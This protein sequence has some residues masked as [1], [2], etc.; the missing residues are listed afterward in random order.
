MMKCFGIIK[1]KTI[2]GNATHRSE[3][4]AFV[5]LLRFTK[6][7]GMKN[8]K[9]KSNKYV[10]KRHRIY[11][12]LVR[13]VAWLIAAI[14]HFK[15]KPKK[16]K[17]GERYLILANHQGMLDPVF[18][19]LSFKAPVYIMATDSIF[20]T[21]WYS[22]LMSHCFA[23]IKKRKG[24]ADISSIRTAV[25]IAKEGGNVAL[26]PEGNRT[27]GDFQFYIDKSVCKLIRLLKLPVLLYNFS[28]GYGVNPRWSKNIR[29][30]KH[31]GV[32]REILS[33]EQINELTDEQ[34]FE[35]VV[36]GL[37]VIDGESGIL[38]KSRKKAEFLEREFFVCPKCRSFSTLHSRGNVVTC[39]CCGLQV[40]YQEDLR[41]SS[42]DEAFGFERA[43]D[44]YKFQQQ[45]VKNFSIVEERTILKDNCVK[46]YD[47]TTENRVLLAEGEMT[48]DS[49]KLQIGNVSVALS[50][51]SNATA[52]GGIKM[53]VNTAEKSYFIVGDER[54][55]CI[56][57]LLF[58][59]RLCPQIF[60]QGGDK[61]YG[62]SFDDNC[63]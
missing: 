54:F 55:N 62:L 45:T 5:G 57:Y 2:G 49:E 59:N 24:V 58:F 7:A 14:F 38:F 46:L 42:A 19:A 27:W 60:I 56:K 16:L 61:Y 21:K 25:Q 17:K 12:A 1:N 28:G 41:F 63:R 33:V 40:N 47:K 11:F 53:I 39:S 13:P 48:L 8:A 52:I 29:R 18:L 26:F 43:V 3:R 34:L 20:T 36:S 9:G 35:R 32:V 23:P 10:K 51:V 30:G 15:T 44:W 50:E 6:E 4:T 22:K 37:K 31:R